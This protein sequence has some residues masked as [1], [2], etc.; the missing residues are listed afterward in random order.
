MT[1]TGDPTDVLAWLR[2]RPR[3]LAGN[4]PSDLSRCACGRGAVLVILDSPSGPYAACPSCI[5]R[6]IEPRQAAPTNIP[7]RR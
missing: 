4:P 1:Y 7:P 6:D 3:L 5:G 2:E